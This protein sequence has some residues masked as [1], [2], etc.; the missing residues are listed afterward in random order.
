MF[1]TFDECDECGLE[2]LDGVPVRAIIDGMRL[3]FCGYYCA[4]KYEKAVRAENS[5]PSPLQQPAFDVRPCRGPI[6]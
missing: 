5:Q 1:D 2:I 3:Q 6:T 4:R